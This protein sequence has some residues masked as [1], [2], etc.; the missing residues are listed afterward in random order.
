MFE[1]L[2]KRYSVKIEVENDSVLGCLLSATF[3]DEPIEQILAVIAIS[4]DLKVE[5]VEGEFVIKGKGCENE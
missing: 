3:N 5:K 2:K 4:F 1:L